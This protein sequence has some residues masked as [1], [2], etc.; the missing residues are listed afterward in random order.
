MKRNKSL[1][2]F[3][4]KL[5]AE[6]KGLLNPVVDIFLRS[7]SWIALNTTWNPTCW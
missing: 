5:E 3:S 2:I 1:Q 4:P 6:I 7:L